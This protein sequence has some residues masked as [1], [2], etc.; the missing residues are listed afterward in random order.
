M[1][2]VN[3]R[4]LSHVLPMKK[5]GERLLGSTYSGAIARTRCE[6]PFSGYEMSLHNRAFEEGPHGITHVSI[7]EDVE[8][9]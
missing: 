3:W 4:N 6:A 7:D 2:K 9:E 8:D 5:C 1:P